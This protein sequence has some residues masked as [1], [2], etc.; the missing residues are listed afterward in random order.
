MK[1]LFKFMIVFIGSM[2]K[3]K[4]GKRVGK[5]IREIGK[6]DGEINLK[7]GGKEGK[8]RKKKGNGEKGGIKK[9]KN[10]KKWKKSKNKKKR[11]KNKN[12]KKKKKVKKFAKKG[13]LFPELGKIASGQTERER[14][15]G[16]LEKKEWKRKQWRKFQS[17]VFIKKKK[18]FELFCLVVECLLTGSDRCG[19]WN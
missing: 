16:E 8:W 7:I 12:K 15:G 9:N 11:K 5:K 3:E 1:K 14:V 18:S 2:I 19:N 10:K 6:N 13:I 17:L 4:I